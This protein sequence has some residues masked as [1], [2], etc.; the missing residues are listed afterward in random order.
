[1][2]REVLT[3]QDTCV[4]CAK[5]MCP[6]TV[7]VGYESEHGDAYVGPFCPDCA[8]EVANEADDR[9]PLWNCDGVDL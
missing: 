4:N 3:H 8:T 2:C 6:G 7:V 9:Q 5:L 1:M